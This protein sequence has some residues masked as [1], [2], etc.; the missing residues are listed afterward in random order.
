MSKIIMEMNCRGHMRF[1]TNHR[2]DGSAMYIYGAFVLRSSLSDRPHP[3]YQDC[4]A[5]PSP[6]LFLF[7]RMKE[8]EW[9]P[10]RFQACDE[11]IV[12]GPIAVP[13][14]LALVW[15][16]RGRV[17]VPVPLALVD[18]PVVDLL[19]LQPRLLHQPRLVL[20]LAIPTSD[21]HQ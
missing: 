18:E 9:K 13:F 11:R 14:S 2:Q 12:F 20:L 8:R 1:N 15:R 21:A 10:G 6:A 7:F 19:Q 16:G 4:S 5:L 17:A 3:P